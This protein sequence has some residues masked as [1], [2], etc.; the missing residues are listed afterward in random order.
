MNPSQ[1]ENIGL[2]LPGP[3]EQAPVETGEMLPATPERAAAP[4]VL[5]R[6]DTP[7]AGAIPLPATPPP[8]I[9]PI[10]PATQA[11]SLMTDDD[12]IEK[13]WVNKAKRI[14]EQTRDDPYKQSE[15]LTVF[16]ADYLKQHYG[17]SIK[18]SQ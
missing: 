8:S 2:P 5:P 16:K 17:K 13:E 4:A 11:A 18:L 7:P 12:L 3:T 9:T 1:P 6:N 15:N 10:T 14:V